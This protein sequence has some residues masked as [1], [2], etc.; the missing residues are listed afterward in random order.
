MYQFKLDNGLT[1]V[2]AGSAT[3]YSACISVNIGH[4]SEPKYGIANLFEKTILMQLRGITLTLGGTMTAYLTKSPQVHVAIEKAM[5]IFNMNILTEKAVDNAKREIIRQSMGMSTSS[6]LKMLYRHTAF[7]IGTEP[8]NSYLD[9]IN[10]YT[11]ED[12][13]EFARQYYT[14]ANTTVVIAGP[15]ISKKKLRQMLQI[16]SSMLIAGTPCPK[17]LENIYTG[18]FGKLICTGQTRGVILGYDIQDLTKDDI[19]TLN[20][21]ISMLEGKIRFSYSCANIADIEAEIKVVENYG[22]RTLRIQVLTKTSSVKKLT[23]TLIYVINQL[24]EKLPHYKWM[25]SSRKAAEKETTGALTKKMDITIETNWQLI[26]RKII[27]PMAPNSYSASGV[28]D[29]DVQALACKIFRNS[30]P[31]YVIGLGK[32]KPYYLYSHVLNMLHLKR[33][34]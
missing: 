12:V 8:Q 2:F 20:M 25:E 6:E 11:A 30:R 14:A 28:S 17:A 24:C 16:Y 5:Q 7:G 9:T 1:V 19:P 23:D 34:L 26:G 3:E 22:W 31:T 13:R 29:K 18:G 15:N 32:A 4:I 33:F 10:S 21:L 27:E